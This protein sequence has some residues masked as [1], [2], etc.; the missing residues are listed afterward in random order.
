MDVRSKRGELGQ[1]LYSLADLRLYVAYAALEDADV[2]EAKKDAKRALYWLSNVLLPVGH[3]SKRPDYS[4]ADLISLFVVRELH[5][6]G[7]PRRNIQTAETY[8]RKKWHTDRPF[9]SGEIQTDGFAIYVDDNLIE[10]QIESADRGGQQTMRELVRE[11]LTSVHYEGTTMH[12]A[13]W[14]PL[15][16]VL[17]DPRVQFGAPVVAGT[18]IPTA[19]I[20]DAAHYASPEE[21]GRQ[22]N[23]IPTKVESALS[24][25]QRL[26]ALRD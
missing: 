25:E 22:F 23:L 14:T 7:V 26:A 10:G 5:Y 8:L 3:H 4:F 1:G 17:V 6:K 15:T 16:H 18:R 9:V 24:F 2:D 19:A 20:S 11:R 21:I 13:Y 12:A